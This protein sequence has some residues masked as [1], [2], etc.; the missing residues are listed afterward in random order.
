M[1]LLFFVA[2]PVGTDDIQF[3]P[4][5]KTLKMQLLLGT[6]EV[7]VSV[8]YVDLISNCKLGK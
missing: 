1:V 3:W 2:P 5:D 8:V 4:L 6:Y 7:I